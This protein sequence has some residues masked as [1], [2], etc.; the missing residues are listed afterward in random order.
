[1][2]LNGNYKI[3]FYLNPL[4]PPAISDKSNNTTK[5]KNMIFAIPAAPAAIPPK[6]NIAATIAT[7]K[8]INANRNIISNFKFLL[9]Y[10]PLFIGPCF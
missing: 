6:P 1:V 4:T 7:A 2:L 3:V 5:T 10:D 8:K 9:N